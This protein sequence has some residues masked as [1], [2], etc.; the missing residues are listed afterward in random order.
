MPL[1]DYK[2]DNCGHVQ[3]ILH[4]MSGPNFKLTCE[5][6]S[7]KK[8]TKQPSTFSFTFDKKVKKVNYGKR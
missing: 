6:C 7:H 5:K 8:L 2:C 1:Y 3:E 4:P